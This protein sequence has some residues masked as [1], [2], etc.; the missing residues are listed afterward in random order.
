ML[1]YFLWKFLM[2]LGIKAAPFHNYCAKWINCLH[3]LFQKMNFLWATPIAVNVGDCTQP[4]WSIICR[5]HTVIMVTRNKVR[6]VVYVGAQGYQAM[7]LFQLFV[8]N[9]KLDKYPN[10]YCL[11]GKRYLCNEGK[12]LFLFTTYISQITFSHFK[13]LPSLTALTY[14]YLT[15]PHIGL[16]HLRYFQLQV[17]PLCP[18]V[19]CTLICSL[20]WWWLFELGT[21]GG[22]CVLHFRG[23]DVKYLLHD[24]CSCQLTIGCR[25][26]CCELGG[27]ARITTLREHLSCLLN[28]LQGSK[29]CRNLHVQSCLVLSSVVDTSLCNG[30]VVY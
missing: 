30:T 7:Q 20:F 19:R 16:P 29:G 9:R 26:T 2:V 28:S 3:T 21:A 17:L 27:R 22:L 18:L 13:K 4:P 10:S 8:N 1:L 11:V 15:Q 23:E 5:V 14:T 24:G 25:I 6:G 12:N